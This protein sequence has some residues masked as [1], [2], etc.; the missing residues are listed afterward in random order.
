MTSNEVVLVECLRAVRVL[1]TNL[2]FE[3]HTVIK[4]SEFRVLA[5]R[6][7]GTDIRLA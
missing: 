5:A 7:I 3:L 2:Q 4:E 1:S 6:L